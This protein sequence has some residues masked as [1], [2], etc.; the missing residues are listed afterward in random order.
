LGD[1]RKRRV[2]KGY[3]AYSTT[4]YI[5]YMVTKRSTPGTPS[6][7]RLGNDLLDAMSRLQERDGIPPSEQVRRA[8]A[9]FLITK[10]VLKAAPKK[11]TR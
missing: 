3:F 5:V 6:T 9:A 7:F 1:R 8:L 11:G 2:L 10:G 4:L